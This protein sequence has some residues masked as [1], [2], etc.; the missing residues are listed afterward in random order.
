MAC[1]T[2]DLPEIARDFVCARKGKDIQHI[3]LDQDWFLAPYFMDLCVCGAR[4]HEGVIMPLKVIYTKS[5]SRNWVTTFS[6][7]NLGRDLKVY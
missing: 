1:T 6:F 7:M 5:P 4:F 2:S 3:T